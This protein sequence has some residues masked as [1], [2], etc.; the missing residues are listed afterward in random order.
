MHTGNNLKN[1]EGEYVQSETTRD[2]QKP[3]TD[4]E[5]TLSASSSLA[6]RRTR[7]VSPAG[8]ARTGVGAKSGRVAAFRGKVRRV[9]LMVRLGAS[10]RLLA[11]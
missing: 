9:R 1:I 11:V 10:A 3:F 7:D 4:F 5:Q 2:S 8:A 6:S